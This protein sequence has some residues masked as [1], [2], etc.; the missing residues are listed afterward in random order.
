MNPPAEVKSLIRRINDREDVIQALQQATLGKANDTLVE[1]LMQG[2]EL[3]RLKASAPEQWDWPAYLAAT[4]PKLNPLK[5]KVYMR[6]A[7]NPPRF[8]DPKQMLLLMCPTD[9]PKE[10]TERKV[11]PA[12][13]AHLQDMTRWVKSVV[14]VAPVTAWPKEGVDELKTELLPI[15][16]ALWPERFTV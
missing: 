3:L 12:W 13:F 4:C 5:A 11:A 10:Q 1:V 7:S 9:E 15:A 6:V 2:Q 14:K 16:K 8:S